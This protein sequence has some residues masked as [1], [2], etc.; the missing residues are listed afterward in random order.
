M[1][2]EPNTNAQKLAQMWVIRI[3][4]AKK[5]VSTTTQRE[6]CNELHPL[7]QRLRTRHSLLRQ[8]RFRGRVYTKTMFRIKSMRGNKT[9]EI[10]VTEFGDL[11]VFP[12]H[13]NLATP[14]E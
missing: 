14:A 6:F 4:K 2:I 12:M 10:F 1:L 11:Q 5:V 9:D 7:S 13:S 8:C 3:D